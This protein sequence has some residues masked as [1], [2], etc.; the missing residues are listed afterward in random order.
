MKILTI[1]LPGGFDR[2]KLL[3]RAPLTMLAKAL[4]TANMNSCKLL[5]IFVIT[6]SFTQQQEAK[7]KYNLI[8]EGLR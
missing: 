1:F 8:R 5:N 6:G 7:Y 3:T 2:T 4:R